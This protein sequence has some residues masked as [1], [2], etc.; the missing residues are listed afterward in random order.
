MPDTI[1]NA[2]ASLAVKDLTTSAAWYGKLIGRPSSSPMSEVKEWTFAGGGSLQLYEDPHR[3]GQGSCTLTVDD[4]DSHVAKL[5][6]LGIDTSQR[7]AGPRVKTV[8]V[9]DPDGNHLAFA[10]AIDPALAR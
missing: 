2:L 7:S 9:A 5:R 8:M 6:L 1:T 10:Q 4:I 3:A